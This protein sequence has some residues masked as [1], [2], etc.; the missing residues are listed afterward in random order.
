[1]SARAA[2]MWKPASHTLALLTQDAL[3]FLDQE[4]IGVLGRTISWTSHE[5]NEAAFRKAWILT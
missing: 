1:M 3:T 2:A 5:T 4:G